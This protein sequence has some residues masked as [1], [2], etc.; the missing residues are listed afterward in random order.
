MSD[1]ADAYRAMDEDNSRRKHKRTEV[2]RLEYQEASQLASMHGMKLK[3][4]GGQ[5]NLQHQTGWLIQLYPSNQRIYRP[6]KRKPGAPRIELPAN[7]DWTLLDVVKA[8]V[9][10]EPQS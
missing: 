3:D 7:R 4:C 1:I 10:A 2:A 6:I 9:A 8:F 5:Y